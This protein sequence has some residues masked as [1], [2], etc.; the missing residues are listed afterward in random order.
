MVAEDI[1]RLRRPIIWILI[2]EIIDII[3]IRIMYIHN[4]N[5][6]IILII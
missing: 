1:H 4:N 5:I 3:I 2:I 6:M